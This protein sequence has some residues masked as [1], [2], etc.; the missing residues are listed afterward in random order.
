MTVWSGE[1]NIGSLKSLGFLIIILF[2]SINFPLLGER[3]NE[4]K[5]TS[6]LG[7]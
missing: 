2:A 5:K 7:N 1:E 6:R 4:L 3:K